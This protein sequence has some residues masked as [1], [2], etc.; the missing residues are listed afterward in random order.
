VHTISLSPGVVYVARLHGGEF[1]G[2][3]RYAMA[4]TEKPIPVLSM[5]GRRGMVEYE[6]NG[7]LAE[8]CGVIS[9]GYSVRRG[10]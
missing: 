7:F 6:W 5:P 2:A 8:G 4:A 3:D 9:A 1:D 10:S